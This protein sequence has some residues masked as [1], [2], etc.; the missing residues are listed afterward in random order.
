[1]TVVTMASAQEF[2]PAVRE[3]RE[4]ALGASSALPAL[5]EEAGDAARFAY[6]EFFEGE[7]S[8]PHTR[9]AYRH[10]VHSFLAWCDAKQ[11]DLARISPALV[12]RYFAEHRGSIPTKKLHLAALRC[13]FDKLVVRHV[14]V[15]NP[16]AS[17]RAERYQVLEGK[18]PEMSV[19]QARRLLKSLALDSVVGLRD[20]AIIGILIYT[21]ARVGA[22]AKLG[23]KDFFYGGDQWCLRFLEKGGKS[24]EIPVRHDLQGFILDYL[25]AAGIQ[26]EAKERPLFRTIVRKTKQFTGRAMSAGDMTRMLKRRLKA[27]GLPGNLSPHSFRVATI[28]N[29]LEQGIGLEEVQRLAGHADPRT[30]RLYDRRDK[31]ITRNLVE[32]ISI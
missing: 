28:T 32:R 14:V 13:F 21:A 19:E 11:L 31:K 15:L 18:T 10:A 24:R 8:N 1:M 26:A 25:D 4:L 12:G 27:A 29:L 22:V 6:E 3:P 30:T 2:L 9:R 23:L 7:I 5:V 16:A 17:V 20:R